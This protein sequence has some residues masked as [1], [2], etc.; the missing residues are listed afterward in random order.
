MLCGTDYP[1]LE[2]DCLPAHP[3]PMARSGSHLSKVKV[4]GVNL[5]PKSEHLLKEAVLVGSTDIWHTSV[6]EEE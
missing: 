4:S 3:W 1:V 6:Q 2:I 5:L